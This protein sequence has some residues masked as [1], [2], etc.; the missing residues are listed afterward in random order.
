MPSYQELE[1]RAKFWDYPIRG[2]ELLI[3]AFDPPPCAIVDCA[4]LDPHREGSRHC[5]S[6]L[7]R[8]LHKSLDYWAPPDP[9][10]RVRS[11]TLE[12]RRHIYRAAP[13]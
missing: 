10:L 5:S 11:L 4:R 13:Q 1:A 2:S 6:L 3:I 7:T 8:V 12:E 9:S